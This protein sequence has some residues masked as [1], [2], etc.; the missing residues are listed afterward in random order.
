M[1]KKESKRFFLKTQFCIFYAVLLIHLEINAAEVNSWECNKFEGASIVGEDGTYLGKLGPS[2]LP[3]SI[4]NSSSS[5]GNDWSQNSIFNSSSIYGSNFSN[6]SAFNEHAYNPPKILSD[7]D[8][9][10]GY[11]TTGS[12]WRNDHY[13]ALDFKYTCDWD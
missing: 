8:G 13:N 9:V 10:I 1:K 4:F 2:W 6:Y 3:D 12:E 11:L 5:Y 7:K